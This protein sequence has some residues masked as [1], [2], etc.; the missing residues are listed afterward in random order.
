MQIFQGSGCGIIAEIAQ[1]HDGSLGGAHALIEAAAGAG[2]WAVKFQAHLAEAESTRE[3]PW[4]IPFSL[5][6]ASR[7]DYWKRM[8]FSAEQW[9]GLKAHAHEKNLAFIVSPFSV[10]AVD[11]VGP[12]GVS[13]WKI[14]S[15]EIGH[16]RLLQRILTEKAP[17]L[18]STGMSSWAEM[19]AV[20]NLMKDHGKS[21][22][23]FQC[24]TAYPSPP[25]TWGLNVL[26]EMKSRLFCP[27]GLSDHSGDI[28]AGLA[29]AALGADFIEV[30]LTLS[31]LAFG[32]DVSSSLTPEQLA[33][34]VQ[35]SAAITQALASPIDKTTRAGDLADVRAKFS[36]SV[37]L[38]KPL[39]SGTV[40]AADDLT[41]KKPAGGFSESQL[42]S[43]I[44]RVLAEDVPADIL[45]RE[46]HLKPL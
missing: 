30:H 39:G 31:R 36:R 41:L 43:L 2:A 9:N 12:E 42:A 46:K 20:A 34:L 24:D 8:E 1:A 29:A 18:V 23:F 4:R 17:V 35:G 21:F 6:D 11:L 32:P 5:Q 44:D 14:A 16:L 37:A 33:L 38:K 25:E 26:Q 19:E 22:G 27:V 45:L 15:G 3:E 28:H 10:E 40:L 7:Y 13:A